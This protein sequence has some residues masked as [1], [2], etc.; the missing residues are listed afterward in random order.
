MSSG[1]LCAQLPAQLE[2]YTPT[3]FAKLRTGRISLQ[4]TLRISLCKLEIVGSTSEMFHLLLSKI[5]PSLYAW[6]NSITVYWLTHKNYH[7]YG[8]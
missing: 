8:L 1:D 4:D 2:D 6:W 7:M 3:R 5:V